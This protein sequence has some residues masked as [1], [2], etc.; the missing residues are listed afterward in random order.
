MLSLFCEPTANSQLFECLKN[1][2]GFWKVFTAF[3]L[4]LCSCLPPLLLILGRF[5]GDG[6]GMRHKPA[7][8]LSGVSVPSRPFFL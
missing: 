3:A 7:S 8:E 2:G 1:A 6:D 4:T 5:S